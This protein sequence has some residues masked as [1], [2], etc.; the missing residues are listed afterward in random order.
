MNR[1]LP[2]LIKLCVDEIIPTTYFMFGNW[3]ELCVDLADK[4]GSKTSQDQRFP[5]VFLHLD[6]REKIEKN[7]FVT[8]DRPS[9]FIICQT[10]PK[11]ST[12]Q[13]LE[14]IYKATLIPIYE[15]LISLMK[16]GAKFK[17]ENVN[18]INNTKGDLYRLTVGNN[19]SRLP[20]HLDAIEIKFTDLSYYLKN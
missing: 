17:K 5:L 20:D 9:I 4:A 10:D 2:D 1:T 11:Y 3:N 19:Q 6:Y 18:E 15:S 8:C 16:R 14:L 7:K 13:R 12:S